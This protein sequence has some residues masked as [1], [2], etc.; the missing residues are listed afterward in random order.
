MAHDIRVL[1]ETELRSAL[2]LDL[3]VVNV[4]EAAFVAMAEGRVVMPPIM[5]MELPHLNAEVDSKMAYIEGFDIFALKVSTG[6]FDNAKVGLPSLGGMVTAMS[7]RDGVVQAVFLDNGYLTDLRTAAAGAVAARHLAPESLTSVGVMGTGLQAR[8]QV[9]AARLVRPFERLLVWGRDLRKAERC[10]EDL[11]R[12]L[13]IAAEACP[14]RETL[15]QRSELVITTTPSFQPLIEADW[16]HPGLHITAMGSDAPEKTE[17]APACLVRAD[18]YVPDS[19]AQVALR[20]ELREALKAGDWP[21][22][23]TPVE[24]GEVVTGVK[25]GRGHSE[26]ITIADLTGTGAQDTAIAS[27]ALTVLGGA[28]QVIST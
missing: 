25:R 10:A 5:S 28:G 27:H 19:A 4:V 14:A 22:G 23:K 18:H 15:V 17:L 1:T 24:L 20:G 13:D 8:L 2:P 26:D 9:R 7:A 16:M 12:E 11:S 21:E 6:F 3:A